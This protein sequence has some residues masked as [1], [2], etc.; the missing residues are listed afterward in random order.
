VT[1]EPAEFTPEKYE[2]FKNYQQNV[3]KEKPHEISQSGFKRFLCESPLKLT[4]RKV[5]GKDQ[6]LGSYH[7][8][9]RLDGRLIAM[10]ILDLLPHCVSGVYMLYHSDFE[11][12]Q[13]GKLSALRE[14]AL[15]LEGGYEY[16]Y[17]GYY[18]HSCTKM[19]YKG[20]YKTQHVLDPESYEWHPLDDE[21]R[22]LLDKKAYVSM[23][24]ERRTKDAGAPLEKGGENEAE[25]KGAVEQTIL[26]DFP[27]P[28][29]AEGGEA[30]K[31]GLSLFDLKVP[32]L[33]TAE[34][35]EEQLDL[36]SMPIRVG[37]RMAEAQVRPT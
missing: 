14:T 30:V 23:S 11:Q 37:G 18:I 4:S 33:M 35:I 16:Y 34:E 36:D 6:L 12:W 17:M 27:H 13:F 28:T 21:L 5:N 2:L 32:G 3:H 22:S 25:P 8:C 9:Y 10:G 19:K 29:A 15:A 1:L 31:N 7:Q 26:S 24:R 20:D